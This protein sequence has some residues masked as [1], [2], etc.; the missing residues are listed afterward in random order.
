MA[1]GTAW[2][3]S[4]IEAI[5]S[6]Y[7]DMLEHELRGESYSKTAH[8]RALSRLLSSRSDGSIERKHQNISAILIEARFP[9]IAGYKPLFNYQSLLAD[10]V[11]ERL[12]EDAELIRIAQVAVDKPASDIDVGDL[13]ARQTSPPSLLHSVRDALAQRGRRGI[14]TTSLARRETPL[15]DVPEKSWSWRSNERACERWVVQI[16]PDQSNMSLLRAAT[17]S[18]STSSR[19]AQREM[20]ALL[21]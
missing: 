12:D 1:A 21:R 17:G 7:F 15:S 5:V 14:S 13:L 16:L 18:D 6:D 4:E 9:W 19:L 11:L 8:R 2:S 20:N 3:E 10:C